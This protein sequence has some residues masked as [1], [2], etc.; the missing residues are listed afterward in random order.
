MRPHQGVGT[1]NG[2]SMT[3]S[4][5]PDVAPFGVL[6]RAFRRGARMSQ[7]QL[8]TEAGFSTVYIGMLE[9]GSR[10]PPET[11]VVSLPLMASSLGRSHPSSEE[12]ERS[13]CCATC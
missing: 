3:G 6:L 12:G 10:L 2:G 11:T 13:P 5:D 9:R 7:A 8:A 4:E 1:R